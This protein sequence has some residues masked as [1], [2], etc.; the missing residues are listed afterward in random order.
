MIIE[1]CVDSGLSSNRSL[2]LTGMLHHYGNTLM[3]VNTT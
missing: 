1:F 3:I 2:F